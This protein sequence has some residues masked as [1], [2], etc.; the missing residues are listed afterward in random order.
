MPI[1]FRDRWV[2]QRYRCENQ[3]NLSMSP[4]LT[5]MHELSV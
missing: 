4:R 3:V 5:G 1:K 2:D